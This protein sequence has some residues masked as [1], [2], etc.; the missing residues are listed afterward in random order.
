[1]KKLTKIFALVCFISALCFTSCSNSAGVSSGVPQDED[2]NGFKGTP[3]TVLTGANKNG[4]A[5]TE[6]NYVLFGDFPQSLKSE[7]VTVDETK[8]VVRGDYTYYKGSDGAWY[9]KQAE[10]VYNNVPTY[11][12]GTTAAGHDG[13][14]YRYFK[15]EPIK[16]RVVDEN[17][18]IDGTGGTA[19]GKLLVAENGL[20][21]CEYYDSDITYIRTISGSPVYYNNY[22]ESRVR[23]YLNGLSYTKRTRSDSTF[24]GK[25]FISTAFTSSLQSKI[26]TT[27]V[28]NSASTT[29]NETNQYECDN[30]DDKLF[31]LS[32][33]E[34]LN[35]SYF[36][37][38][39]AR[40]RLDTDFSLATGAIGSDEYR[41]YWYLRSPSSTRAYEIYNISSIGYPETN[42]YVGTCVVPALCIRN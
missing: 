32:H 5:G 19:T 4:T 6:A 12:D 16:W 41:A 14:T 29:V 25:G 7:T 33:S 11:R 13:T 24:N 8:S 10:K 18:D 31:L 42:G 35:T 20:V 17:Y 15:V 28:D 26:I 39:H 30:T 40:K 2:D 22:K 1:M 23:A 36:A 37:D 38:N 34:A 3:Y 9:V 21:V 27:K